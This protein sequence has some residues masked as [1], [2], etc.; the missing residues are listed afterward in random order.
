MGVTAAQQTLL[1]SDNQR[2]QVIDSLREQGI[3]VCSL[4]SRRV[5]EEASVAGK[6]VASIVDATDHTG[7]ARKATELKPMICT[8]G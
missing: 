4:S 5:A 2:W 3:I 1:I 8:K 7:L 6:E